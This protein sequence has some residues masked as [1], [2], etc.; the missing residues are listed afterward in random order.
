MF[1]QWADPGCPVCH[2][3]GDKISADPDKDIR[4]PCE[5]VNRKRDLEFVRPLVP[6]FGHA[7]WDRQ[8]KPVIHPLK[9]SLI[10][11][12]P[13]VC[14]PHVYRSVSLWRRASTPW[15]N[16]L[17][18]VTG[19]ILVERAF[20]K[21]EAGIYLRGK[22]LFVLMS[23]LVGRRQS[24]D[25]LGVLN[26]LVL[27]PPPSWPKFVVYCYFNGPEEMMSGNFYAPAWDQFR[28]LLDVHRLGS[29]LDG[30][31]TG[32]P[33]PYVRAS[34]GAAVPVEFTPDN[35]LLDGPRPPAARQGI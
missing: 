9:H 11:G 29:A 7:E 25:V 4:V 32:R 23:T 19:D 31:Q 33:N 26:S 2:G 3:V 13:T 30:P 18:L 10:L 8:A 12:D 20:G 15:C 28:S 14:A 24:G 34:D 21:E 27:S 5:C 35:D 1:E 6:I 22:H 17:T 16:C